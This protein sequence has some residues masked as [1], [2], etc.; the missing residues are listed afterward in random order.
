[1]T[2]RSGSSAR[3]QALLKAAEAVARRDAERIAREKAVQAA[4]AEFFHAQGEIERI[5]AEAGKT[6]APFEQITR[7]AVRTLDRLG[8]NRTGIAALTGLPVARVREY[9]L[10]DGGSLKPAHSAPT[11]EAGC[12]GRDE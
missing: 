5:Y 3:A 1:M 11:H 9:V 2:R 4:L 12:A 10:D 6:A 7:D 8:E